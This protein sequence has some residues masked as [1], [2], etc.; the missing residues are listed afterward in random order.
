MVVNTLRNRSAHA[1]ALREPRAHITSFRG[2]W[3]MQNEEMAP[4]LERIR[5]TVEYREKAKVID[6]MLLFRV[7]IIVVA[8]AVLCHFGANWRYFSDS[9]IVTTSGCRTCSHNNHKQLFIFTTCTFRSHSRIPQ[10]VYWRCP[11]LLGC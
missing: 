9:L 1:L 5:V 11:N 2:V 8:Y 7:E 6:K 4:A 10:T 3:F